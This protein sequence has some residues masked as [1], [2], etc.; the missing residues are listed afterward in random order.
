MSGP[1]ANRQFNNNKKKERK[2]ENVEV[3][4][5]PLGRVVPKVGGACV[6]E[7]NHAG[8]SPCIV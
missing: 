3:I 5:N 2:K 4:G 7:A 1:L 6:R 8:T